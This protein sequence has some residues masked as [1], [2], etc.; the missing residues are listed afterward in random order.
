MFT[1]F[2]Q[3]HRSSQSPARKHSNVIFVPPPFFFPFFLLYFPLLVIVSLQK[4]RLLTA[5]SAS[6]QSSLQR[7]QKFHSAPSRGQAAQLG[8]GGEAGSVDGRGAAL[9]S[10]VSQASSGRKGSQR[11]QKK[12]SHSP[13]H[14]SDSAH[15]QHAH[16]GRSSRHQ[17][18]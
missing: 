7:E 6:I 2:W 1:F 15:S 10:S 9:G 17:R 16:R 5:S 8:A 14:S 18:K 4:L 3:A 11:S 12:C 13:A